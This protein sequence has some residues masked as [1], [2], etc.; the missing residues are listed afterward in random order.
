MHNYFDILKEIVKQFV[1]FIIGSFVLLT[2][3]NLFGIFSV[4]SNL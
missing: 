4:F 3:A 2:I 1:N